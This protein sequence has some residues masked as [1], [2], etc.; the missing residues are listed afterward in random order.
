MKTHRDVTEHSLRGMLE[1]NG[2]TLKV[3]REEQEYPTSDRYADWE[4]K[5]EN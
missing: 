2:K 3:H 4:G 5:N 1:A